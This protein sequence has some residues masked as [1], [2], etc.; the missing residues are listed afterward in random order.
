MRKR[1]PEQEAAAEVRAEKMRERAE[2]RKAAGMCLRC[3][4]PA[5]AGYVLCCDCR[6]K[7]TLAYKPKNPATL[8]RRKSRGLA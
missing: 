3:P 5:E 8:E 2:A 1:T 7:A 4:K 6:R